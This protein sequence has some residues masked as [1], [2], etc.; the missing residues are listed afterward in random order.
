MKYNSRKVSGEILD[1]R[2]KE[3]LNLEFRSR[4]NFEIYL[5]NVK[6][7]TELKRERCREGE[8]CAIFGATKKKGSKSF[9]G[10]Y[11]LCYLPPTR[12]ILRRFPLHVS[13]SSVGEYGT[14]PNPLFPL[15]QRFFTPNI[16][17]SLKRISGVYVFRVAAVKKDHHL[18]CNFS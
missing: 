5:A 17:S 15:S 2:K 4:S 14:C 13:I 9:P 7:A 16:S 10:N 18:A 8:N 1:L 11:L 3:G 12:A 6:K